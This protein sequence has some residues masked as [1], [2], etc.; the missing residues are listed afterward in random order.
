LFFTGL[1]DNASGQVYIKIN[2]SKVVHSSTSAIQ[3]GDWQQWNID[4]ASIGTN[5]GNITSL[6]LGVDSNGSGTVFVDDI[7][8]YRVAP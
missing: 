2:G 6:E 5:L 8:L 3:S 1:A 7:R 4:L